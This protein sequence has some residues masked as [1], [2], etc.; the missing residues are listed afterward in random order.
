MARKTT[1]QKVCACSMGATVEMRR[2]IH[3]LYNGPAYANAL[4]SNAS[5]SAASQI[6]QSTF[7]SS[8]I[9]LFSG[10]SCHETRATN[11]HGFSLTTLSPLR[12][13]HVQLLEIGQTSKTQVIATTHREAGGPHLTICRSCFTFVDCSELCPERWP[14]PANKH[15]SLMCQTH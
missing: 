11:I 4:K 1:I 6:G 8:S 14:F 10:F 12:K 3:Y 13:S 7:L 5:C 15:W 9:M 2:R